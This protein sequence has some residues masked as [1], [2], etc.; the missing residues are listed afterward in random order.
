[1]GKLFN[2]ITEAFSVQVLAIFIVGSIMT[3]GAAI[4]AF[5]LDWGPVFIIIFM[6]GIALTLII[7]NQYRALRGKKET[8]FESL[9]RNWLYK[10]NFTIKDSPNDKALF[11]IIGN[12]EGNRIFNVVR[13]IKD[14]QF[15]TILVKYP[16]PDVFREEIDKLSEDPNLTF[17]ED[18]RIE[19]I[20]FG[21]G[22]DGIERPLRTIT[23]IDNVPCDDS[24]T[25]LTFMQHV[26]LVRQGIILINDI[27]T[28]DVKKLKNK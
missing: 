11:H 14:K 3:I 25:E 10:H 22:Y 20:R 28:R 4:W 16:V 24:L 15:L 21:I 18:L 17:I 6:G 27:L 12:D 7:I 13:L 23:L 2:R 26:M 8:N 19:L 1:M 5:L 9:V